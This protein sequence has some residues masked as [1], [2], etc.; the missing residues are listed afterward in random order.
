M[1]VWFFVVVVVVVLIAFF[2]TDR[3]ISH[4]GALAVASYF[5]NQGGLQLIDLPNP[6]LEYGV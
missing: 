1:E 6:A 4:Y 5:V 3:Q 2:E